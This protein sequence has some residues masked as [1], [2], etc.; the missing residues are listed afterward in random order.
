MFFS[1]SFSINSSRVIAVF[2]EFILTIDSVELE[3][4]TTR[5]TLLADGGSLATG[6]NEP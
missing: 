6:A 1:F 3:D 4:L 5:V 2:L